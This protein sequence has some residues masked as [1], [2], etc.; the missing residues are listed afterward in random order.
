M[1]TS[2]F[3][4]ATLRSVLNGLAGSAVAWTDG[5]TPR[6]TRGILTVS[7][8]QVDP[9]TG[10]MMSNYPTTLEVEGGTISGVALETVLAISPAQ[11]SGITTSPGTAVSYVVTR[12]G[13]VDDMGAQV[14]TLQE[15]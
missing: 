15:A 10:M 1:P 14:L 8:N 13:R 3:Y 9:G 7:E 6:T 5:I 12:V 11:A 4:L 2:T